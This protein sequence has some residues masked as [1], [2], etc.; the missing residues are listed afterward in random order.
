M[1]E[2]GERYYYH[3][4]KEKHYEEGPEKDDSPTFTLSLLAK[5]VWKIKESPSTPPPQEEQPES[6]TRSDVEE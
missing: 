1:E 6:P 2:E 3:Y 5:Q 4:D